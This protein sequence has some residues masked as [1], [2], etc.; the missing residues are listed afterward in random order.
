VLNLSGRI[1]RLL[2]DGQPV[3]LRLALV[4]EAPDFAR[5]RQ[6]AGARS[7]LGQLAE[8]LPRSLAEILLELAGIPR[9]LVFA[10]LSGPQETALKNGLTALPLN[11][12]A[13]GGFAESMATAG[14]VA[15][16]EVRPE[17][18]ECRRAPRLFFAGEILDLDGPTGGWNLHWAFASGHLAGQLA[19]RLAFPA[20]LP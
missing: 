19:G 3:Q 20:G 7:I 8:S 4:P 13:T 12:E 16:K 9:D 14:G 18:L 6:L 17:T 2:H 11:I 15:L 5:L 10:R 1:S